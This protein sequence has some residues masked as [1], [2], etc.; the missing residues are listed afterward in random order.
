[1]EKMNN[2]LVEEVQF[3]RDQNKILLGKLL[4]KKERIQIESNESFQPIGKGYKSLR[5]QIQEAEEKSMQEFLK[6]QDL[7]NQNA[8]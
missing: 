7:E 6:L 3:L 8:S 5:N 2:Q 4:E 1:M